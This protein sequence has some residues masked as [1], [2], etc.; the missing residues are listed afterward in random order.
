VVF[1]GHGRAVGRTPPSR[2]N[3]PVTTLA[4]NGGDNFVTMNYLDVLVR[5]GSGTRSYFIRKSNGIIDPI[6]IET[7][8]P[9]SFLQMGSPDNFAHGLLA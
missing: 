9:N 7:S 4:L 8:L 3:D 1:G 5:L 2:S 6:G